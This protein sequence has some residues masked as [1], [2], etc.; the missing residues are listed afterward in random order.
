MS[1]FQRNKTILAELIA[2]NE[3]KELNPRRTADTS[4]K[5]KNYTYIVDLYGRIGFHIDDVAEEKKLSKA[6][7]RAEVG[8]LK[9]DALKLFN[10]HY[11]ENCDDDELLEIL[12]T[13]LAG[14]YLKE[15]DKNAQLQS[16]YNAKQITYTLILTVI[17]EIYLF[18][19]DE[20]LFMTYLVTA[21]SALGV[22][23]ANHRYVPYEQL[24]NHYKTIGSKGGSKKG[25]NYSEPRQKALDYHDKFF[26]KKKENGK[27]VYSAEKASR[28]I[29]EHFDKIREP[30]GYEPRPLARHINAHRKKHFK[31]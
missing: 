23:I 7:L 9:L 14:K 10:K 20:R 26:S 16:Q 21:N 4:F 29:I 17:S 2:Q 24:A 11:V 19:G 27:F 18:L 8:Q 3:A 22:V 31:D 6:K 12:D 25:E 1:A 15:I 30:L 13:N 5:S 28:I